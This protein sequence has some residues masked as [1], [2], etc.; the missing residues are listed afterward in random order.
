MPSPAGE[1]EHPKEQ[2]FTATQVGRYVLGLSF[3]RNILLACLAVAA[4][5]PLYYGFVLTPAYHHLLTRLSEDEARRTAVHLIRTLGIGHMPLDQTSLKPELL[6]SIA[7]LKDDF[8]LEKLKIFDPAGRVLFSTEPGELNTI[9][10]NPYFTDKVAKGEIYS[11]LVVKG[12]R[13]MENEP[14]GRD[15]VEIYIPILFDQAFLGAFE[16]YY[17]ITAA[18]THL[19]SLVRRSSLILM[20]IALSMLFIV[21]AVLFKAAKAML[22]HQAV[23]DALRRAHADLEKRVDERTADL[24]YSNKDLQLEIIERRQAEEALRS[25]EA[26]FRRLIE[27]MPHGI[28]EIDMVGTITFVNPAHAKIYGYSEAELTGRSMFDLTAH[29]NERQQLEEHLAYLVDHQPRPS[30]WYT[31][32]RTKDGRI[33]ETQVDWSYKRD[34]EGRIEGLTT[35]ISDI[36]HRKQAEK[37]LLDNIK[38]MNTLLDTIPNPVFFKDDEGVFLGCNTAYSQTLG[39]SKE[40]LLGQ[41]LIDLP[42]LPFSAM[43]PEYH[44]QDLMLI[45]SPGIQIHE[46]QVEAADGQTKDFMLFKATFRDAEGQVAGL[47]GIMLDITA[48]KQVEKELKESKGLFDAFM[49]HMP[50][51]AFMKDLEGR[52]LF[53]NHAFSRFTGTSP[54]A[55]IG[56]R[57][58]QVWDPQTAQQLQ[59][60]D[61]VVRQSAATD[62]SMETIHLPDRQERYLL[63]TRFPIFQDDVLAAMGGVAIDVTERNEA[64]QR[65]QQLERQLQQ[66]Q[67]ME[68]L[69]TLAGGIAHD[70]NNILAGIIGYTQIAMAEIKKESDL[71][72]YLKRVLAAGERAGA[73]VKQ[74]LTFSRQSE[75]EPTP[76]QIKTIVKEVLKLVRATLPVTIEMVQQIK[77]DATVMADPVQIHQVM[78]NLC[79]NAGYAMRAKGG[80][81]TVSLDDATLDERFTRQYTNLEPG[82]YLKLSVTDTGHGIAGEHIQRIFDPFFTTKPKGEGTG[83]GLSVVHGIVSSLGGVVTVESALG[84]GARFDVYLPALQGLP[85]PKA[86]KADA[87]PVGTE[88]ILFVDDERFQ[89]D[90]LKHMLGL[91]G[92]KVQ[93]ANRGAEALVLLDAAPA[94]FDLVITDMVMP[95]MT[96]D[97]LSRRVLQRWPDMPIIMCTGYSENITEER[98]KAL[99]IRAFVL[100][101]ISMENLAKLIREILDRKEAS[102]ETQDDG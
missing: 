98:A 40:A 57:D 37:A 8:Q 25:S 55:P 52:Y 86:A 12:G 19:F 3:L 63:T 93:T 96:G 6:A 69:G 2:R 11:H 51:L 47:V 99:G 32:D 74:I 85:A 95:E 26:R 67:K 14:I 27:T 73:L 88:R 15:V 82:P 71:Y 65:R 24:I 58:D 89:S 13:S 64:E 66:A 102:L 54:R 45:Q 23:D 91:L 62:S 101:P 100:K 9:N 84:Q 72:G 35:V 16:I 92:Y 97:E 33:I 28:R 75:I 76:V 46:Q 36:T 42:G 60:N 10:R 34:A 22:A 81:L 49:R 94:P 68:A 18:R 80:R 56:L 61:Q 17:D 4:L 59:A 20:F 5:F 87:M 38:F 90:M 7:N 41:R 30:P 48:R 43:A 79:A 53:V 39:V 44:R 70:F 83:M 31:K 50:G 1:H 78:M 29:T 77:S 21:G